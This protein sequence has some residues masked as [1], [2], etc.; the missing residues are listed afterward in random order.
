MMKKRKQTEKPLHPYR[1]G[2]FSRLPEGLK[3]NVLKWWCFA[4][5][6]YFVGFGMPSIMN[7][8]VDTIFT[9]GLVLGLVFTFI[10]SFLV[11]G[12]SSSEEIYN[13]HYALRSKSPLRILYNVF[14]SWILIIFVAMTYQ[15]VNSIYNMIMG[16]GEGVIKIGVEPILY[17]VVILFYDMVLIRVFSRFYDRKRK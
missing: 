6:Y 15:V 14:Y 1:M 8:I 16:Y 13:K 4:A 11:N 3:I 17:G 5:T 9:L 7:S 12:V 10:I 2:F